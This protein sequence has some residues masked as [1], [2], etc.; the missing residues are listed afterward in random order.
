VGSIRYRDGD[1]DRMLMLFTE[2]V[3]NRGSAWSV[4]REELSRLFERIV[5]A[6]ERGAP[7]LPDG[8]PILA[9]SVPPRDFTEV[10]GP[11]LGLAELL[12]R[13]TGEL[14]L[15]LASN[16][17]EPSF[18]PEPFTT[19]HQ[20]SLFQSARG[21]FVRLMKDLDRTAVEDEEVRAQIE[22]L[23]SNR[24]AVEAKLR[25]VTSPRIEVDR[26]R[27]HGDYHL[28]QV[29]F[30]GSDFVIIDFEGEPGRPLA[31]RRYKRCPLR[32]VAGMLRS[33]D[34]VAEAALRWGREREED[35]PRLS[36]WGDAVRDWCEVLF[37]RAYLET[38]KGERFIP[39]ATKDVKRLLDFYT[40]EKALYEV[41]YE[42]QN[43]PTWLGLPLSGLQRLVPSPPAAT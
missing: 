26:I 11:L 31:E 20:Q 24:G 38:T 2:F 18:K 35:V 3:K 7:P 25:E 12:G 8:P 21:H 6:P 40:I 34:Y 22:W 10:A 42:L 39:H 36:E 43:R 30:T 23:R 29:L 13:R 41:S 37:V 4:A 9:G 16:P 19:L 28:G 17:D 33:F 1:G 27:C 14:H 32:D 5:S 15:S